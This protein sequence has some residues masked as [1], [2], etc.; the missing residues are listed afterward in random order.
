MARPAITALLVTSVLIG[1]GVVV[2][3]QATADIQTTISQLSSLD[4]PTRMNAARTIRRTVFGS[5][6]KFWPSRFVGR[7]PID[8]A[9][10]RTSAGPSNGP[11]APSVTRQVYR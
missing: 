7:T 4:Y 10:R 5:C 8:D 9:R 6:T 1:S 2:H 11:V 3:A